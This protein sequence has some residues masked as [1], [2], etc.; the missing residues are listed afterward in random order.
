MFEV[1]YYILNKNK[2]PH[3]ST[4]AEVLNRPKTDYICCGQ[5]Q[6]S[7]Y[8]NYPEAKAFYEKWNKYHCQ[9][10]N[11]EEYTE[12]LTDISKLKETYHWYG[13][14]NNRTIPFFRIVTLS[15]L[16]P[17]YLFKKPE[18]LRKYLE[19]TAATNSYVDDVY[20]FV[21]KNLDNSKIVT[22]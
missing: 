19:K 18:A 16:K 17:K 14:S 2:Y 5:C 21:L 3:F 13:E 20:S 4:C 7:V 15:K 12:L 9:D 22:G 1:E 11:D 8:A 10:L 6:E